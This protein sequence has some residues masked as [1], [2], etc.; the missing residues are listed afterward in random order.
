MNER[1]SKS[2]DLPESE[3]RTSETTGGASDGDFPLPFFRSLLLQDRSC[4]SVEQPGLSL[5]QKTGL[6]VLIRHAHNPGGHCFCFFFAGI[7]CRT[8]D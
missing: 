7:I 2:R 6:P 8:H 5:V 1:V 4:I 3:C